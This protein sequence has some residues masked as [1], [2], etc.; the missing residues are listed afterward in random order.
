MK[1]LPSWKG[2]SGFGRSSD[3]LPQMEGRER[4]ELL[5]ARLKE[6]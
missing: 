4:R 2:E 3:H 5:I 6:K 1:Y